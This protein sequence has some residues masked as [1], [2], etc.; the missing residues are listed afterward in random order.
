MNKYIAVENVLYIYDMNRVWFHLQGYN[1]Y[2]LSN[3]GYIRS[4]K[5][6]KKYPYGILL[7]PKKNNKGIVITPDDPVFELSNDQNERVSLHLSE[8]IA[9]ANNDPFKNC[10]GYPRYTIARDIQ[11]RNDR[12]FV[13]K[14]QRVQ[15]LDNTNK[16]FPK[17]N[18]IKDKN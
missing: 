4:M 5:H 13:K 6:H 3:D 11:S 12:N 18:I 9:I 1:G 16:F 7:Q 15:P 10:S 8:L 14:K 2:E 17:F